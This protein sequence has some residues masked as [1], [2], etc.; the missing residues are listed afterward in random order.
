M[1]LKFPHPNIN[2]VKYLE[3]IY[4]TLTMTVFSIEICHIFRKCLSYLQILLHNYLFQS[5]ESPSR[6]LH[7]QN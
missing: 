1:G 3:A 7:V 6:Q 5:P 2:S 4:N